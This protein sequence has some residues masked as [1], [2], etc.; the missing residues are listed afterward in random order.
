[1]LLSQ[2]NRD[3]AKDGREPAMHD[4]RDSGD[5][6][7][8]ADKIIFIHRPAENPETGCA[9]PENSLAADVPSFYVNLIQAKGRDDGTG[10]KPMMFV[11]EATQFRAI[12]K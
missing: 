8:D 6:E 11:R 2:L 3:S 5:I 1:L 4:L 9:Q 7:Q 10:F 12:R